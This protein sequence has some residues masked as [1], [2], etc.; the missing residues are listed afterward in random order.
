MLVRKALAEWVGKA[1][2][3]L[4]QLKDYAPDPAKAAEI[5]RIYRE[6]EFD[7][8]YPANQFPRRTFWRQP[9]LIHYPIAD[10]RS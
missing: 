6:T 1:A 3:R 5:T 2:I 10:Q 9:L 4:R 7:Y 8:D